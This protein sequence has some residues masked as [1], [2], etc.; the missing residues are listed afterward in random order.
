MI[1]E[2]GEENGQ[3]GEEKKI[4]LLFDSW[5]DNSCSSN[6]CFARQRYW[7]AILK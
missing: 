4:L 7:Y 2:D 1:F 6:Y 5:R 3:D